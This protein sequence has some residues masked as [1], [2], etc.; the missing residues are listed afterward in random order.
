M[1]LLRCGGWFN[2]RMQAPTSIQAHFST[3]IDPRLW[4]ARRHRLIDILVIALSAVMCGA[5]HFRER[6]KS[7]CGQVW[8]SLSMRRML[9][10]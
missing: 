2:R 1:R 8:T 10:M 4:R 6:I 7:Q 5:E 3:L 9:A